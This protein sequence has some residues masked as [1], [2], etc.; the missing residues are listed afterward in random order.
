MNEERISRWREALLL[1]GETDLLQS[2]LRDLADYFGISQAEA[3]R[4]CESALGDSKREWEAAARRTP[5]QVIDFYDRTRSYIFEHV[6]WHVVSAEQN[7]ANVEILDCAQRC[8]AREYLDFGSGVGANAILFARSGLKVTLAD[9][10]QTML[11]FARWRIERRGLRAEYIYLRQAKLPRRR[12]DFVT[13]VD[14]FEH[15]VDPGK[16]LWRIGAALKPG[17]MIIF[18]DCTGQDRERPMHILPA[19]APIYLGLRRSGF[20]PAGAEA[21][22]VRHLGFHAFKRNGQKELSNLVWGLYNGLRYSPVAER[23]WSLLKRVLA[24]RAEAP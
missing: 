24:R 21:D 11:D 10:S 13:A 7:A 18:N 3:E 8:G 15:L 20:R 16:E 2:S 19:A 1:P 14:V 22:P 17:G 23:G 12:F 5:E 6:W 9:V 4:A